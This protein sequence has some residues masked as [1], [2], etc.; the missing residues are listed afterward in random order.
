MVF[1]LKCIIALGLAFI[2][3][4]FLYL[5]YQ[6]SIARSV[7]LKIKFSQVLA[8]RLR[9]TN[10]SSVIKHSIGCKKEDVLLNPQE[11]ESILHLGGDV[12]KVISTIIDAKKRS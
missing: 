8:M 10:V 5:W 12:E 7:G 11:I 6:C 4:A 1:V 9:G 2:I 3:G